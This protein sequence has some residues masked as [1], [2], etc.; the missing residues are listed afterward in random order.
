MIKNL[1]QHAPSQGQDGV[2]AMDPAAVELLNFGALPSIA[3]ISARAQAL[4]DLA[5]GCDYAMIGGA[6]YLM[7]AL[8]AALIER[9]IQPLF[10]FTERKSVEETQP[11]GSVKKSS[12]FAHAG[13]V[14]L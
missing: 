2:S 1:T 12:V 9:K 8:C 7:P 5:V 10:A 6:P 4:A 3:E 13:W 11:D 14:T